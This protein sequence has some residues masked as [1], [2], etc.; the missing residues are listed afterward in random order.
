VAGPELALDGI[1][2]PYTI[3]NLRERHSEVDSVV[4]TGPWRSVGASNNAFVI[5]SFIDELAHAAAA[6]PLAWRL[7]HLGDAARHRAV[8]ELAAARAGWGTP[9]PAGRGRG[10]AVY[11]SFGSVVAQVVEV[12]V[13]TDRRIRALRVVCAIDCGRVVN[14]DTVRAQLEGSI[15]MGVSAALK[16]EVRIERG[17]VVQST[18]ADYPI[19]TLSEMPVTEVHIL[20]S[21]DPPGGVGEP[22]V[23][24]VAPALANAVFAASGRRLRALPLRL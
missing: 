14:P 24:V 4:P 6:D 12:S 8:L 5:E 1:D 22:G 3:A 17:R 20:P 9:L 23:P 15:A 10:I 2:L 19:L 11:R 18:F 21:A 7:A 13:D 16:E